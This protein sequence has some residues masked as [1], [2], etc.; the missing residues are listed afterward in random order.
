MHI[1]VMQASVWFFC[2]CLCVRVGVCNAIY[3][4]PSSIWP[5]TLNY[6]FNPTPRARE[7][8]VKKKKN[9]SCEL[10]QQ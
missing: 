2:V 6:T 3:I 10:K 1:G 7:V 5:L 9:L 4:I 8:F